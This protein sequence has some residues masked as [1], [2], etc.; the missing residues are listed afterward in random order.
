DAPPGAGLVGPAGRPGGAGDAVGAPRESRR[1]AEPAGAGALADGSVE[2][3]DGAGGGEP[4]VAA[5]FRRGPG[6][7]S[8]QLRQARG[9]SDAPGAAGLAGESVCG[10]RVG[11]ESA[12]APD[13]DERDV[14]A[15]VGVHVGV[16]GDGPGEPAAGAGVAASAGRG[17]DPGSGADDLGFA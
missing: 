2:S 14:P 9:A 8:G 3:T 5:D 17:C 11:R 15:V 16:D 10:E 13:G 7:G 6:A 12:G 4:A 1:A